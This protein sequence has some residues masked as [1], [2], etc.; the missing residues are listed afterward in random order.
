MSKAEIEVLRVL[1]SV[2]E[3]GILQSMLCK[4]TGFS[5]S[6]ISYVLS[7][8]SETGAITK[9]KR[10]KE[11]TIWLTKYAPSKDVKIVRVGF[12]KALEYAYLIP[13]SKLLKDRGYLLKF[14]MYEEGLSV[15]NDLI[16]GRLDLAIAP[17]ITQILR[18]VSV[19]GG[20]K[21]VAVAGR[22]G[23][24]LVVSGGVKKVS[25]LIDRRVGTTPLSTMELNVASLALSEGIDLED[26]ELIH[27]TSASQMVN[28][29]KRDEVKAVSL[30][31][32]YPTILEEVGYRRLV[33][34]RD[35]F[36][37]F[38]CCV[39]SC[40]VCNDEVLKLFR[41]SFEIFNKK[42]EEYARAFLKLI[43]FPE[44][45]VERSIRD[46]SFSPELEKNEVKK[47]LGRAGLWGLLPIVN[48]VIKN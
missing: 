45:L 31:E 3:D 1:E 24:S 12:I 25:D 18:S 20:I 37:D 10:G 27:S 19:K 4:L 46:L 29:L 39:L 15:L 21:I 41:M 17:L 2:R 42:K 14:K 47:E 32:P 26:I 38:P 13:F 16:Q 8:L 33:R 23:S 48:E 44:R 35:Y 30:W 36:S 5:K 11:Y 9:V 34:Y 28:M 7:K 40:R 22:G 43:G 6:T